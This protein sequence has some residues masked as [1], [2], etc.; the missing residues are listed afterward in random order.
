MKKLLALLLS[1]LIL[2][3]AFS[4]CFAVFAEDAENIDDYVQADKI[5]E[6]CGNPHT[7]YDDASGTIRL[8][9]CACCVNCYYLDNTALTKCAKNELGHYKGFACCDQCT[10][11]FPCHCSETNTSCNCPYCGAISQEQDQGP[12]EVVPAKAKNIFTTVFSN[13]M[14]KL[15]DVFENLFKV[16]FA[17]FGVND[18]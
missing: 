13:V 17:V 16:I 6:F 1:A 7:S 15:S 18:D 2:V 5:C 3:S 9:S 8:F 12:V 4:I 11:I 14:G 10:G